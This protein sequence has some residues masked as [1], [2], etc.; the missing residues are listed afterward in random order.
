MLRLSNPESPIK[1]YEFSTLSTKK[2]A[3]KD[4]VPRHAGREAV[5]YVARVVRSIFVNCTFVV[6]FQAQVFA[7]LYFVF[8][9]IFVCVKTPL[10]LNRT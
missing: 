9:C 3:R 7:L 1:H 2:R 6:P 8:K 10:C 5:H 4:S